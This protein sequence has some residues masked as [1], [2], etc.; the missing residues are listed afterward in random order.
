MDGSQGASTDPAGLPEHPSR[1]EPV[2]GLVSILRETMQE[3]SHDGAIT[4]GAALAYY[5]LFSLAPLLLLI[6]ALVGLIYGPQLAESAI[7]DQLRATVGED[8]A[9]TVQEMLRNASRP[10]A[11]LT[12]TVVSLV[13]M[14]FGASAA[15]GQLR[16]SL[17]RILEPPPQ[18]YGKGV[19][20][21]LRQRAMSLGMIVLLG[22]VL[23]LSLVASAALA[24]M[25]DWL[26]IHFPVGSIVLP[27]ANLAASFLLVAIMFM[28]VFKV[29][30]E[31]DIGW[32]DA[33]I[34]GAFTATLF[35]VGK[36]GIALYLGR[37]T[38]ASVYGAAGSLVLLLLWIY[39]SAQILFLGAEFTEVWSRRRGRRRTLR[40]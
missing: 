37:A 39:Y 10:A 19:A 30:P 26:A 17:R 16:E 27:Y 36:W 6:I 35:G 13:T 32:G 11:G 15:L 34:G 1:D 18:R 4:F 9:K 7:V 24:A 40:R 20:G 31:S 14:F 21:M 3:W 12:A 38:A 33:L 5:T 8:G 2:P 29:L 22:L 23:V 25:H 28:I